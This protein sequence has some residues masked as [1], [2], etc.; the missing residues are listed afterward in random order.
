MSVSARLR[1]AGNRGQTSDSGG[2]QHW[3]TDDW[4]TVPL[5]AWAEARAAANAETPKKVPVPLDLRTMNGDWGGSRGAT[6]SKGPDYTFP[7][8]TTMHKELTP[9]PPAVAGVEYEA[10]RN[11]SLIQEVLPELSAAEAAA[12]L[13]AHGG[14]VREALAALLQPG[15]GAQGAQLSKL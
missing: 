9:P 2:S 12:A 14:S 1:G 11:V 4:D 5:K 8:S 6:F 7:T 10:G 13:R 3:F 15:A